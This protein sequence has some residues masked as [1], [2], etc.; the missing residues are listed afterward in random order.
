MKNGIACT[1]DLCDTSY[2]L[3]EIHVNTCEIYN[4]PHVNLENVQSNLC[5]DSFYYHK[6]L[7]ILRL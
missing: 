2:C 6:M 3:V 1:R 7:A 4:R 5:K